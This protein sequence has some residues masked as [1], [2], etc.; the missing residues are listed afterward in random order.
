MFVLFTDVKSYATS[1]K[2]PTKSNRNEAH[3]YVNF[4]KESQNEWKQ[5]I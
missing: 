5:Y 2:S 3:P 1:T 4:S